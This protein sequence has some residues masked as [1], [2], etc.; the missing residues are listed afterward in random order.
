VIA[1][2]T[3]PLNIVFTKDVKRASHPTNKLEQR[4][5]TCFFPLKGL[6]FQQVQAELSDMYYEQAFWP[7]ALDKWGLC[8]ADKTRDL[9]D[10]LRS[11]RP[12]ETDIVGSTAE[13]F[14]E[15]PFTSCKAIWR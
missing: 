14:R 11:G 7:P 8:F 10:E 13:L 12:K 1:R 2:A 9:K 15:K 6:R 3:D 5:M 4:A